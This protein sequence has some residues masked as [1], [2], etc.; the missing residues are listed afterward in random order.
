MANFKLTQTGEQIHADLNLLDKNSATSGQVLTANGT[1][2][3]SWQDASGGTEVVQN[4]GT[5]TTAVMSQKA[6]TDA[7]ATAITTAL[8]TAV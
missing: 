5:S 7:I 8:N 1:G 3:A 2:G 6:V 4:T